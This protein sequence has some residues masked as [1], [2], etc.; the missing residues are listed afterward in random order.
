MEV[1]G[2]HDAFKEEYR[3]Y[4][5]RKT[6]F[7]IFLI[8]AMFIL[9]GYSV[10]VSGRDMS[11]WDGI[12]AIIDHI[13][14]VT[15]DIN[16][17]PVKFWNDYI[18]WEDTMPRVL[19]AIICGAGLAVCGAAM[20]VVLNNP[21]A[22]PY[23]LGVSSGAVFGAALAIILGFSFTNLGTYGIVGNAFIFSLV[24]CVIIIILVGIMKGMSP[25]T[26]IL[27]GTAI[28]YF[29][30]GLTTLMMVRT[31][32]D[33]LTSSFRWQIGD[34]SGID[35]SN[36]W[37]IFIGTLICTIL[38]LFM[39]KYLNALALGD[40]SAT[41]LGVDVNKVR[42]IIL[43]LSSLMVAVILSFTGIIGF[44][45]LLAPHMVRSILGSDN[46]FVIPASM[47]LGPVILLFADTISRL[48]AEVDLPVG[49]V[50]MFVGSPIF[51][52]V[53]LSKRGRRMMY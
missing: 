23:T 21:L 8:I 40:K 50:M 26:M 25:V 30:S 33:T 18:V 3:N 47:C 1:L 45:G 15:Y 10:T 9:M 2:K 51:L 20:Q 36:I 11:F 48:L 31:D 44:I 38:L 19:G 16:T 42:Y 5:W 32:D 29:F 53:L 22:E 41:S 24:P 35:W 46:K 52:Y 6:L 13:M 34:L 28:S 4:I 12:T 37:I 14:G 7:I 49:V 39:T 43:I 17:D 27:A